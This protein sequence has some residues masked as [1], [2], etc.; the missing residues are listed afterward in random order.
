MNEERRIKILHDIFYDAKKKT[1]QND[2]Y[3]HENIKGVRHSMKYGGGFRVLDENFWKN[4]DREG[5]ISKEERERWTR[6]AEEIDKLGFGKIGPYTLEEACTSRKFPSEKDIKFDLIPEKLHNKKFS[7]GDF[8]VHVQ[9]EYVL[10]MNRKELDEFITKYNKNKKSGR[11]EAYKRHYVRNTTQWNIILK[12]HGY[13]H[14]IGRIRLNDSIQFEYCMKE[15]WGN[16]PW[17]EKLFNK[18]KNCIMDEEIKSIDYNYYESIEEFFRTLDVES[19]KLEDSDIP[20]QDW[21][22]HNQHD[23]KTKSTVE[24]SVEQTDF[25]WFVKSQ[26]K[27]G[28]YSPTRAV[29]DWIYPNYY[30]KPKYG[31]NLDKNILKKL[32]IHTVQL[33]DSVH[34]NL[35][36]F[37]SLDGIKIKAP[38]KVIERYGYEK[39]CESAETIKKIEAE[40][41]AEKKKAELEKYNNTFTLMFHGKVVLKEKQSEKIIEWLENKNTVDMEKEAV[42]CVKPIFDAFPSIEKIEL[43]TFGTHYRYELA[44]ENHF[45]TDCENGQ[46]DREI[47]EQ[48][49]ELYEGNLYA[50]DEKLLEIKYGWPERGANAFGVRKTKKGKL[51]VYVEESEACDI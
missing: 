31:K 36:K 5:R 44:G 41:A 49:M 27:D 50:P 13:H 47:W 25:E 16:W 21:Y 42:S 3:Y 26:S 22:N 9:Y 24:L 40:R 2:T 43:A 1:K 33:R 51:E 19:L 28:V 17:L 8:E 30:E 20:F 48:V 14:V 4:Y 37:Y 11:Y 10:D 12:H 35:K 29:I 46:I 45:N 15:R 7:L 18:E 32:G 6:E 34:F 39:Y 38:K 23:R